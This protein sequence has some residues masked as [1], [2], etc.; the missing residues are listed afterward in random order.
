M[1]KGLIKVE[2][3]GGMKF[4]TWYKHGI[5]SSSCLN[6]DL[7]QREQTSDPSL[8]GGSVKKAETPGFHG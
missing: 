4:V 2:L 1:E 6:K 7:R 3:G 5:A 8:G